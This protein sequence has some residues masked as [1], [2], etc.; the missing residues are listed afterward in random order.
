MGDVTLAVLSDERHRNSLDPQGGVALARRRRRHPAASAGPVHR[1]PPAVRR[2]TQDI[3]RRP[4]WRGRRHWRGEA[5]FRGDEIHA[6]A[7]PIEGIDEVATSPALNSNILSIR[8]ARHVRRDQSH[9]PARP[10]VD[11]AVSLVA[12][13]AED[14]RADGRPVENGADEVDEALG[15]GP[16]TIKFPPAEFANRDQVGVAIG[17]SMSPRSAVPRPID[18]FEQGDG[19]LWNPNSMRAT[20]FFAPTI[21]ADQ[22]G[23]GTADE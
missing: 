17:C 20:A 6:R 3:A 1:R 7:Q 8:T 21:L 2:R 9:L 23:P 10:V 15:L 14:G 18:R 11:Q 12:E 13:H 16:L 4:E 5:P 19:S 22:R